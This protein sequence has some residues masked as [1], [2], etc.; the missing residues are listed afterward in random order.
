MPEQTPKTGLTLGEVK[1]Y[2][3]DNFLAYTMVK[4]SKGMILGEYEWD[5]KCKEEIDDNRSQKR[6]FRLYTKGL[7]DESKAR[8]E[9]N[10]GPTLDPPTMPKPTFANRLEIYI[11][12]K[13]DDHTIKFGFIVQPSEFTKKAICNVI[14]P[15]N[16]DKSMLISEDSEGVFSYEVLM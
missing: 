6:N 5:V 15:D 9:F 12:S 14:M 7:E 4:A 16:S 11:K 1:Q 10:Q 13:I 3:V 8:W 2:L